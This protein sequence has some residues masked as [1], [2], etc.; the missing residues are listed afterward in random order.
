MRT[1]I[2]AWEAV[3]Y[4]PV[5]KEFP[6]AY[7]CNHIKRT[8][9]KL[10]RKCYLGIDLYNKMIE[11]L[12]PIDNA[13]EYDAEETYSKEQLICYEG[14]ILESLIDDNQT[15][16]DDDQDL[17]PHWK[18]ADKFKSACYQDL[19]DCHLKYW[20]AL[21]IIFTSIRY[22]T[23]QAGAKGLVKVF[24]DQTGIQTVDNKAFGEFKKELKHDAN[25]QLEVMFDWMVEKQNSGECDFSSIPKVADACGCKDDCIVP[26]KRRRRRFY[27]KK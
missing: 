22:A 11:D 24:N 23:Y 19:W 25:D 15:H 4:G 26:R 3:K 8:E 1:L 12:V 5:Q 9:L 6:T 20:L 21:E 10:F 27:F 16:P 17:N 13:V 18:I 2:T 7:I 14:C